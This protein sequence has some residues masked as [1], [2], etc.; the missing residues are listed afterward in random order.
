MALGVRFLHTS[1][2]QLGMTRSFLPTESQARYIDDQIEAVRALARIADDRDCAF[3]VIAGDVFD[4]IQPDRRIVRRAVDALGSFTI[5]VY[6]LPGNHD[7]DNP[8][9]LWSTSDVIER[10][11]T[12]VRVLRDTVPVRVPGVAAEVVGAPWPSRRP[13]SDLLAA[14][15]EALA[16]PE[17]G[18]VRIAV[19]HGAV[20]SIA[21]DPL[22]PALISV[23][24]LERAIADGR[25]SYAAL[26]DRHS[27]TNV[28]ASGAVWYS[29]APLATD[30]REVDPNK[31]LVVEVDAAARTLSVEPVDV[32]SWR[33]VTRTFDVGAPES[34]AA[35]ESFLA[36]LPRKEQTVAK[37]GFVG[38]VNLATSAVLEDVVDR[39][40]DLLAALERSEKRSELVVV[41]DDA[42][43]AELDLSGFARA[44]LT[45]LADAANGG[46]DGAEV[47]RDALMLLH[48]MA[49]R[50][51]CGSTGSPSATFGA[52]SP[53]T[54]NCRR[55]G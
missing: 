43:L 24:N 44:A 8:A 41:A 23:S 15:L 49:A 27:M 30:Y 20:D 28:G 10:L 17:P 29:G 32:G 53:A 14:A 45:E 26:G 13:D 50:A 16:A 42:D 48:R 22:D 38:T 4:S 3:V 54:S 19:G 35:V 21:P 37:L 25:I 31:A 9:A 51:S 39:S 11:P 33:F 55:P 18:V 46:A 47:S 52:W 36:E 2:W 5:P 12:K 40:R 34:V 7:A 1:D 6:L